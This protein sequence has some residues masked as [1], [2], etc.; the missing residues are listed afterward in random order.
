MQPYNTVLPSHE[1]SQQNRDSEFRS[2]LWSMFSL[3][4]RTF[5]DFIGTFDIFIHSSRSVSGYR[6]KFRK[7]HRKT[8]LEI[9]I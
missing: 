1:E 5:I 3:A 6:I 9:C 7:I 4:T 8:F 2:P